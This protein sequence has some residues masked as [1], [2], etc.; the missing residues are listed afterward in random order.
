[1][2]IALAEP[3]STNV[4]NRI[5]ML[6]WCVVV[7]LVIAFCYFASA[8]CVTLVLACF[9]SILLDP[10][11][12]L[13]E[14]WRLPRALTAAGLIIAGM[15]FLGWSAVALVTPVS[16]V[17][18]NLPYYADEV[19]DK[20]APITEGLARMQETAGK[21]QDAAPKKNVREVK[22]REASW[23]SYLV[24]GFGSLSS[25]LVVI[26]IVPFLML[27]ILA[28]KER[29]YSSIAAIFGPKE[30]P[31]QFSHQLIAL[32][33]RF[34]LGNLAVGVLL[35]GPTI[36]LLLALHIHNPVLLGFVSGALN[37]IPFLGAILAAVVPM[38]AA[39]LQFSPLAVIAAIGVVV[40]ALHIVVANFLVPRFIGS[41]INVGPVA[42]IAGILF[43]GWLWG[44]MGVLLAVP[45]TG[46]VKL[47]ADSHPH[48]TL[49]RLSEMLGAAVPPSDEPAIVESTFA[50]TTAPTNGSSD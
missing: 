30:N 24:R 7:G 3:G 18:E 4:L 50:A 11:V 12:T 6:L 33:R 36:G 15:I 48:P 39:V 31:M 27:F 23:S 1:M 21:L 13:F 26:G 38:A 28:R 9:L 17:T 20:I 40:V 16:Q 43:W 25:A 8:F 19:R 46:A 2:R 29:W 35:A 49:K 22:L 14:R 34:F 41:R 5:A 47:I 45:L 37:I 42:A 32:V 10:I 44:T